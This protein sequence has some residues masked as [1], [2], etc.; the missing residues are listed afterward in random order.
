MNADSLLDRDSS[1]SLRRDLIRRELTDTILRAFYQVYNELGHGFLESIYARAMAVALTDT[2]LG[3]RQEVPLD[4][5]FRD[6]VI[7][8]FK[9]DLVVDS[10]VIV[11]LK[12]ARA[13]MPVHEAQLLNCLRA[14]DIE[15]GILLNFGHRPTFKRVAFSNPG[16]R[17]R[18][19]SR[20]SG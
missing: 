12:A 18:R 3:V 1:R 17:I 15:V 8:T 6:R 13:L 19:T 10:A 16:K 5:R 20:Q 14:T 2:G 11:E 7:G 9:A 4:V